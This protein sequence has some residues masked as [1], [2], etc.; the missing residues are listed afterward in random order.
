M[1]FTC[2]VTLGKLLSLFKGQLPP[3]SVRDR[4]G[5][6]LTKLSGLRTAQCSTH[7]IGIIDDNSRISLNWDLFLFTY[8]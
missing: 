6:N 8:S 2:S 3:L 5:A 1:I 7:P 4:N